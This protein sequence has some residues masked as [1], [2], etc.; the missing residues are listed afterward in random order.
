[1]LGCNNKISS[2]RTVK[3]K[4]LWKNKEIKD[5]NWKLTD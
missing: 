2:V 5:K 1:M 3:V 4:Q